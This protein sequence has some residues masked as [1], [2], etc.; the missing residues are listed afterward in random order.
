MVMNKPFKFRNILIISTVA[1]LMLFAF[2]WRQNSIPTINEVKVPLENLPEDLGGFTIL[3]IT[4]L[5]GRYFGARQKI[6]LAL[7]NDQKYDAIALTG[8]FVDKYSPNEEAIFTI[9]DNL[10]YKKP[11]YFVEGNTDKWSKPS[12][13]SKYRTR[14]IEGLANRGVKIM[15]ESASFIQKGKHKVWF[16]APAYSENNPAAKKLKK[17]GKN[18]VKIALWHFPFTSLDINFLQKE[19]DVRYVGSKANPTVYDFDLLLS[20]HTHG[21]QIRLPFIGAIYSPGFGLFPDDRLIKGLREEHGRYAYVSTGLGASAAGLFTGSSLFQL[22]IMIN[23]A[24]LLEEHL[25]ANRFMNPP[26]ITALRLTKGSQK[27]K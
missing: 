17:A 23:I 26:E 8:D 20:G 19:L 13:S 10:K 3:Q 7:I 12:N 9:I 27:N 4:D 11:M 15:V 14:L 6:I 5:H 25:L 18:D 22:P 21:G 24:E 1:I 16:L 2:T